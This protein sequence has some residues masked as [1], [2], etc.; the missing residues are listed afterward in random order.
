MNTTIIFL[1][2]ADTKKDPLVNAILWELSEKGERQAESIVKIEIMH[3]VSAIYSS[4]EEKAVLTSAPLAKYLGLEINRL[5]YFNEVLRGDKFLSKEEFEHEK[6][7]Q[8]QDL[9]YSAFG[10]ESG[11]EALNRFKQGV[12][13]ISQKHPQETILVVTHGTILNIYFADLL[14]ANKE[15]PLRW[16]QTQF[17]AYGI[18]NNGKVIKDIVS[19]T[20]IL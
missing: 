13:V 4:H 14:N 15:L 17:C 3:L 16:A 8:L 18:V 7:R 6:K 19:Q 10:G 20:M 9:N 12:E 11:I 5:A 1:R 2:H